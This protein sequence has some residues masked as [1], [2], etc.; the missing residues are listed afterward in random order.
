MTQGASESPRVHVL[1][2]LPFNLVLTLDLYDLILSD[3]CSVPT[4]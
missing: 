2:A 1:L 3:V 4:A